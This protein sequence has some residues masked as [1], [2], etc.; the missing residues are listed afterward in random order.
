MVARHVL[1]ILGEQLTVQEGNDRA[2]VGLDHSTLVVDVLHLASH[3]VTLDNVTY[4]DTAIH[5]RQAIEEVLE[6]ILHRETDTSREASED[7]GDARAVDMQGHQHN[8]DVD[9]PADVLDDIHRQRD[10]L[11]C[12]L[13]LIL[14]I[15]IVLNDGFDVYLF[16][17]RYIILLFIL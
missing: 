17:N 15:G 13:D 8:V 11:G 6:G 16:V 14:G 3:T 1:E 10:G 7:E 5:Q 9:T 12:R 4:L 2:V